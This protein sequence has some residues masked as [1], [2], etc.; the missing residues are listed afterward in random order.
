M[1]GDILIACT[2]RCYAT[3]REEPLNLLNIAK[4]ARFPLMLRHVEAQPGNRL[5]IRCG[6]GRDNATL[7]IGKFAKRG[8]DL[9]AILCLSHEGVYLLRPGSDMRN[10]THISLLPTKHL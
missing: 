3:V 5:C 10:L 6:A 9:T 4:E 2:A 7:S 1:A 8:Y